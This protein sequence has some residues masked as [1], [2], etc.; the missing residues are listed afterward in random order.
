MTMFCRSEIILRKGYGLNTSCLWDG[1]C[2]KVA[3]ACLAHSVLVTSP[4]L[5]SVTVTQH[6]RGRLLYKAKR[7][8]QCS[9]LED[10]VHESTLTRL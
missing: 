8:I 10:Q 5:L 1:L 2:V 4:G 6:I 3:P 9:N 7:T